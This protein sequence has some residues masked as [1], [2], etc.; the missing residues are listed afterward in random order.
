M[1]KRSA[2][3]NMGAEAVVVQGNSIAIT[4]AMRGLS[5]AQ[6]RRIPR[7]IFRTTWYTGNI[8]LI[9]VILLAGYSAVWEYSTRKYLKGFSD[10]VIP[11]SSSPEEK[12][13]AIL[14]WMANGPAR[15][16]TSPDDPRPDR[17]PIDTLNY[18]SLL[19]ICGSATNAFLNLADSA[20]LAVRRLLLLD[21]RHL[22][23][24]VVAEVLVNGRWIVVDPAFRTI[25][26]GSDGGLLTREQL[27]DPAVFSTATGSISG[28]DREYTYERT[29]HLR[30]SRLGTIGLPLRSALNR[31][32]PGWEDSTA[33][34]LLMERDS[35]AAM[36]ASLILV[37][38][39][40]LLRMVLRWYGERRLGIRPV[41]IRQQVRRAFH[42]FADT[43]G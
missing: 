43:A 41:R 20:G 38:F 21:S 26:R 19:K 29:A 10:A 33:L 40:G 7:A 6:S 3:T 34:S 25:L 16:P 23:M 24:H 31:L 13:E 37:F 5:R 30:M 2:L 4:D 14:R 22:T 35:L 18:A 12:A 39:L 8:L 36:V 1:S 27:T 42:A 17:D 15:Q 28:Y 32:I 9:L 11:S